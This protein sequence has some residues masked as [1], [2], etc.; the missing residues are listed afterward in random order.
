VALFAA[1]AALRRWHV[2][3][4]LLDMIA[5]PTERGFSALTAADTP[6]HRQTS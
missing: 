5:A 1:A 6:A 4:H 3:E 2:T